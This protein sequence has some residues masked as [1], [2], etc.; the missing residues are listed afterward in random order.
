MFYYENWTFHLR[1]GL[2]LKNQSQW[3]KQYIEFNTQKGIEAGKNR[4]KDGKAL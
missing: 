1:I 4:D 2:E 3:L